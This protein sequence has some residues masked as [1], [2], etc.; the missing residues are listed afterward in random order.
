M[1][2]NHIISSMNSAWWCFSP[3]AYE[4]R[5]PFGK[6]QSVSLQESEAFLMAW[7]GGKGGAVDGAIPAPDKVG[8]VMA[9]AAATSFCL[10]LGSSLFLV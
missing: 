3:A 2:P 4:T 10:S 1:F 7:P 6:H 9:E 5:C 8:V